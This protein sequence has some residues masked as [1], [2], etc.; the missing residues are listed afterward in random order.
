MA[1]YNRFIGIYERIPYN[2]F[3]WKFG[4]TSFRTR[5]FNRMTEWQLQLLDDFWKKTENNI[6]VGKRNIWL[7]GK[8]ISMKSKIDITTGLLKTALRKAMTR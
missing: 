3:V 6:K 8:R 1:E 7:Q 5:E 2:S 4:T